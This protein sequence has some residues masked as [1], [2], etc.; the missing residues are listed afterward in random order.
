MGDVLWHP[1][2]GRVPPVYHL[3]AVAIPG[4]ADG[5]APAVGVGYVKFGSR[6]PYFVVPGARA[7]FVVDYWADV[8]DHDFQSPHWNFSGRPPA[9]VDAA[10]VPNGNP[11]DA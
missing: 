2:P 1:F 10:V 3:V 11:A 4:D 7:N 6:G 5:N 9:R 8:F